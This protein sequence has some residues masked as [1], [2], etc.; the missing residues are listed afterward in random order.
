MSYSPD[1]VP[2]PIVERPQ[3]SFD[4]KAIFFRYVGFWPYFVLSVA[5]ALTMAFLFNRYAI[6]RY[7]INATLLIKDTKTGASGANDFLEGFQLLRTSRNLENEIGIMRS[8]SMAEAT[9]RQ[10]D[11][12][13]SYFRDGNVRTSEIYREAP[14]RV[15]IDSTHQQLLGITFE[16]EPL[17]NQEFIIKI[18]QEKSFLDD[19]LSQLHWGEE[20]PPPFKNGSYRFGQFLEGPQYR[21]KILLTQGFQGRQMPI[22]FLMNSYEGLAWSYTG[23]VFVGTLNKGASILSLNMQ[24]SVPA[25]DAVYLNQFM[26]TY[27]QAGLDEKN[28]IAKNT[29]RFINEQLNG[30]SDSLVSVEDRLQQFRT[31][32]KA[33]DLSA[34]STEVFQRLIELEK[35]R[36]VEEIKVRYYENLIAY[37]N[38]TRDFKD[39]V[40]PA[41]LGIEDN[42]TSAFISQLVDLYTKRNSLGFSAKE[43]NF[44]IAEID[45]Q[46]QSLTQQLLENIRNVIGL[47][48]S[49]MDNT[50][51]RIRQAE[52]E[53]G[54]LPKTERDLVNI[55]RKFSLNE[56]LYVYLLQKRAEAGIARASNLPDS[57]VVDFASVSAAVYPNKSGNYRNA[58]LIGLL[59]PGLIIFAIGYLNDT[60]TT[61]E[62]LVKLTN[63]PI[64]GVVTHSNKPTNLVV[65]NNPKSAVSETFRSLRSNLKY[66]ASGQDRKC[67]LITSGISGEGKTFCSINLASVLSL[68]EKKTLLVGV[69]LRKPRIFDD[70]GF[71][72]ELGLS[73]YLIGQASRE[74]IIQAT[75]SPFLDVITAGPIAPNPSELLMNGKFEGLI[76][77]LRS[78]YEYIVLDSP[79]LGLVAD[80]FE[81]MRFSDVLL[82]VVRQRYTKR[83]SLQTLTDLY[84]KGV[85]KN[86]SIVL[87]DFMTQA[88]YGYGNG[89][90]YGYG[91]GYYEEDGDKPSRWKKWLPASLVRKAKS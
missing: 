67:I 11:F 31:A 3:E 41:V 17:N 10:L 69:D 40:A 74:E 43:R 15:E 51:K 58:F 88:G 39:V 50:Q 26:Q 1:H 63:V 53:I 45:S 49:L 42:L 4:I 52:A 20:P 44:A 90:G 70:F 28:L 47:S 71:S 14:I 73:N 48:R 29:I 36:S 30:V 25:K 91:Y 57:K 62:E 68:S 38:K 87:N 22:Q 61:R 33:I 2:T 7:N 64:L 60:I 81:L 89:Y 37:V 23:R 56:N 72:N 66:L 18:I 80:T 6:P 13:V 84:N 55:K 5:L 54:K 27:I 78:E 19:L 34:A 24:T 59:L 77:T 32:N 82:Y 9:V 83:A 75:R 85:V 35:Q 46:I 12:G 86:V 21:F 8:Y 16:V 65:A 79:P 76:A